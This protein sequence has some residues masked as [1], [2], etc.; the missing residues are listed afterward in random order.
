[1]KIDRAS[2]FFREAIDRAFK[3]RSM[4]LWSAT[5]GGQMKTSQFWEGALMATVF[6]GC[7]F[8][9]SLVIP[10]MIEKGPALLRAF[11]KALSTARGQSHYLLRALRRRGENR[12]RILLS[13]WRDWPSP[14]L[15]KQTG[16]GL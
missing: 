16:D 9:G 11:S 4:K 12:I 5:Q 10:D 3:A 1:V 7:V 6:W 13:F 14:K 2:R 15:R 8:W